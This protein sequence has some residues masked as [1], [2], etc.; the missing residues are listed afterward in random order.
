[1]YYLCVGLSDSTHEQSLFISVKW[2]T[3]INQQ[4]VLI[5][6]CMRLLQLVIVI[7]FSHPQ[8]A[9]MYKGYIVCVSS[10]R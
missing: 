7:S 9:L 8:G 3:Y 6:I 5:R 1:M 2:P 4:I 10:E